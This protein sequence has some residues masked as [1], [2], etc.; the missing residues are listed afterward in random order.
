MFC[1]FTGKNPATREMRVKLL[2]KEGEDMKKSTIQISQAMNCT[3]Q[4]MDKLIF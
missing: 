4:R 2:W 1:I 3:Y